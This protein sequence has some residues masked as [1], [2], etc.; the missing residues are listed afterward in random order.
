M[1][2]WEDHISI[3]IIDFKARHRRQCF[4]IGDED[5]SGHIL[6]EIEAQLQTISGKSL[7]HYGLPQ[8]PQDLPP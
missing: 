4:G 5:L 1:Q 8:P 2:L 6:N 7:D 3:F